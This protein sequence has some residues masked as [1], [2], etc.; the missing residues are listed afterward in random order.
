M[1][2]GISKKVGGDTQAVDSKME[3][4]VSDVIKTGK[5]KVTAIKI[6]KSSITNSMIQ[7]KLEKRMK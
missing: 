5:D 4:C 1:P 2:Y 7:N 6:C 3:R